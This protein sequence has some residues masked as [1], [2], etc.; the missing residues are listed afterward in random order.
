MKP[1]G[2]APQR[3]VAFSKAECEYLLDEI[4]A[5][6]QARWFHRRAINSRPTVIGNTAA[7]YYFCGQRQMPR[8][9]HTYLSEIAPVVEGAKLGEICINRYDVGQY[10]P[11]HVDVARYRYNMV[12]AL[13]ESGDGL[14]I[15]GVFSADV[16]GEGVVFP[17][18][19]A[20]HEVPPA[21]Q[22]RY[23]V[24]FLYE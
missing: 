24:I 11:E 6:H 17:A 22:E 16:A 3:V 13:C 10:M 1:T 7:D 15:E 14:T 18:Y 19:S 12:I 23:V 2:R 5:M 4:K 20:P 8:D 9:L 21:T